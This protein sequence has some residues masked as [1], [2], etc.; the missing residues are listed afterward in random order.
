MSDSSRPTSS[1]DATR[2]TLA[3][4]LGH[5]STDAERTEALIELGFGMRELAEIIGVSDETIR[6]WRD[7]RSQPRQRHGNILDDLRA[8]CLILLDG[9]LPFQGGQ[10]VVSQQP[11]GTSRRRGQSRC[12]RATPRLSQPPPWPSSNRSTTS[13]PRSSTLPGASR[14]LPQGDQTAPREQKEPI[15]VEPREARPARLRRVKTQ[16]RAL[17]GSSES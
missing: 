11:S 17:S 8:V 10:A 6:G 12:S 13:W 14:I 1:E 7:E 2:S 9:G 4:K 5:K 15:D 3:P 16:Q